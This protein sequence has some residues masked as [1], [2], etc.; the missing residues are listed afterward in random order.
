[1]SFLLS[2]SRGG[3]R[4]QQTNVFVAVGLVAIALEDH[5]KPYLA[6]IFNAIQNSLKVMF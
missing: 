1:M 2:S 5:I 3:D 6:K 4:E